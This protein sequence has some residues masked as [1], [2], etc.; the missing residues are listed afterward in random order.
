MTYGCKI[1]VLLT[2]CRF[3][4]T[5]YICQISCCYAKSSPYQPLLC[6]TYIS[7]FTV[8]KSIRTDHHSQNC[9]H[10]N[11]RN[12]CV[13]AKFKFKY[14]GV[15]SNGRYAKLQSLNLFYMVTKVWQCFHV[16]ISAGQIV[17]MQNYPPQQ[18]LICE[19]NAVRFDVANSIRI[20]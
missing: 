14:C 1:M 16:C 9:K 15:H 17:A 8:V 11:A 4:T 5:M 2:L 10:I 3:W 20:G 19:A 18:P 12:I 7:R 6:K 13:I